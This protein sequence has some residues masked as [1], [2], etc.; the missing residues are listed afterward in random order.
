MI[1]GSL[2]EIGQYYLDVIDLSIRTM[3][4]ARPTVV[5]RPVEENEE[6]PVRAMHH[7]SMWRGCGTRFEGDVQIWGK[8]ALP[9][10]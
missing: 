1:N 9:G 3:E 8:M 10:I 4:R 7:Q 5:E 6:P 2:R